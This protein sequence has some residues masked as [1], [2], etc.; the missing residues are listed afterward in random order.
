MVTKCYTF[1]FVK[2][3][4]NKEFNSKYTEKFAIMGTNVQKSYEIIIQENEN[5]V[6]INNILANLKNYATTQNDLLNSY[7]K[8]QYLEIQANMRKYANNATGNFSSE[9][10]PESNIL[11]K[12]A[13]SFTYQVFS[14]AEYEAIINPIYIIPHGDYLVT[15][16]TMDFT[17]TV[18]RTLMEFH[19][20]AHNDFYRILFV[21]L[22]I[23][24][25]LDRIIKYYKT[26]CNAY[27]S[28][29]NFLSITYTK[30]PVLELHIAYLLSFYLDYLQ[31]FSENI[32]P[33][34]T[35]EDLLT[36]KFNLNANQPISELFA[37]YN[38]TLKEWENEYYARI[39]YILFDDIQ[40]TRE[41]INN[42]ANLNKSFIDKQT[43]KMEFEKKQLLTDLLDLF[44]FIN[45]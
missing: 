23:S 7:T 13:E 24:K 14:E 41:L 31:T 19:E 45:K 29:L 1:F 4:I 37:L 10:D 33:V 5:K 39:F 17:K 43:K 3:K 26:C 21:N 30:T 38:L 8:T 12:N 22:E 32:E 2:K 27:T 42:N 28:P 15:I 44:E 36:V 9:I 25:L 11:T 16:D 20:E 6:K 35:L 18:T 34:V 40:Y